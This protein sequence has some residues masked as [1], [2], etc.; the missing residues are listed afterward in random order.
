[1]GVCFAPYFNPR[2]GEDSCWWALR[3]TIPK[4]N[5]WIE[6]KILYM[7]LKLRGDCLIT[8]REVTDLLHIGWPP[9]RRVYT[10]LCRRNL[11]IPVM[12]FHFKAFFF[13]L[14]NR[15]CRRGIYAN[16]GSFYVYGDTLVFSRFLAHL[17]TIIQQ[18][19][20]VKQRGPTNLS[21]RLLRTRNHCKPLRYNMLQSLR[22][23]LEALGKF[24]E[25]RFEPVKM[26][27]KSI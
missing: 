25:T 18:S 24:F 8:R 3:T 22:Y 12:Q 20:P 5:N 4:R 15:F 21:R 19:H 13:L 23:A 17:Q 2:D 6:Q 11:I 10:S 9:L 16:Y 26:L 14:I 27:K 1:M 7:Q